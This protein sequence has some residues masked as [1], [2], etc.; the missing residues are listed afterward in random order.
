M[1]KIWITECDLSAN[2]K[3][4]SEG[5]LAGQTGFPYIFTGVSLDCGAF[6]SIFIIFKSKSS[7]ID[8]E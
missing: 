5:D 2:C 8:G 7:D 6:L 1:N 4:R 3:Y